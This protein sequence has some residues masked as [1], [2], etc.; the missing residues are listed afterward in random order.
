MRTSHFLLAAV[1]A[2]V[3]SFSLRAAVGHHSY[4]GPGC[5]AAGHYEPH[6]GHWGQRFGSGF[7]PE[8]NHSPSADDARSRPNFGSRQPI[9]PA[10]ISRPASADSAR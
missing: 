6:S 4:G 3:T 9:G 5:G 2:L 1:V 8:G 10:P 7:G